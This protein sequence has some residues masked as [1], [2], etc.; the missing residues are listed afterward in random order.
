MRCYDAPM[1]WWPDGGLWRHADFLRLWGAQAVSAVGNRVT[2]TTLPVLAVLLVGGSPLELGLLSAVGV[3]PGALVAMFLGGT[4]DRS[5]KRPILVISD[6]ARAA[7]LMTIPVAAWWGVLTMA[8]LYV[9]AGLAGAGAAIF[10]ITDNTYLPTLLDDSELVEGNSKLE[11]TEAIAE[12]TGPGMAGLLVQWLTAPVAIIFDALTF[13]G[14]A[15]LLGRIERTEEVAPHASFSNNRWADLQAG[16]R[17]IWDTPSVKPLLLASAITTISWGA[18]VALYA[19]LVMD[20]LGMSPATFGLIISVGGISALVGS[21]LAGTMRRRLGFGKAMVAGLTLAQLV[22][23]CVP[24]ASWAHGAFANVPWLPLVFL[25]IA[26]LFGDGLMVTHEILAV[27]LRQTALPRATLARANGVFVAVHGLLLPPSALL[28]GVI[29][30]WLDV[31]TALW[32]GTSFGLLS[33]LCLISLLKMKAPP[34]ATPAP[35]DAR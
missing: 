23:L 22:G 17:A 6:L 19:L 25:V 9:V 11:S 20:E 28:A 5:R 31:E 29:A 33:P 3:A 34:S 15:W 27:S 24:A 32:L 12:I 2:R 18:F 14:S 1:R 26:Q 30:E 21:G 13:L 35:V 4:V 7:L 8:Q 16:F 10:Q